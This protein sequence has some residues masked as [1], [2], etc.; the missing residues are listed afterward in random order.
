MNDGLKRIFRFGFQNYLR[1]GWLSLAATFVVAMTLF[2]SS[3]F[4]FQTYMIRTTTES[5][6][7]KLDMSLYINDAPSEESV[8]G[9]VSEIKAYPEVKELIYLDKSQ[10][11]EEWNKLY[12]DQKIK[13]QVNSENNPL[14][15]TIKIKAHDPQQLETIDTKISQSTFASNIRTISYRNNKNVIQQL[16]AQ[17]KK[18][19]RNGIIVSSLFTLIAFVFVYNTLR[20]IIR[21]RQDEISIM[22]L[23]GATDS[24]VRGPF[25][26][27]GA[28]YGL[29]AGFIAFVGLYFYLQN[30]LSES[31]LIGGTDIAATQQLFSYFQVHM[32]PIGASLVGS[33]IILSILCSWVSLQRHLRHI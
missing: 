9:F 17:S 18:V 29:V 26:V 25:I 13:S 3:V 16:D 31:T 7:S 12:V 14:P 8:L 5:I 27:E 2:I 1:N 30:G 10:V 33:G 20:I 32:L 15:R 28:L 23:V 24:F 19:T 21:F 11:I 22:K 6:R 4:L